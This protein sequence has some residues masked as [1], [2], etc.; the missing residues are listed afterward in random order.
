MIKKKFR[1]IAAIC[2]ASAMLIQSSVQGFAAETAGPADVQAQTAEG[3]IQAKSE[4]QTQATEAQTQATEAQT[5]ATEAQTQATEAQTQSTEA[6]TQATEALTQATE[7]QTQATESQTQATEGQTQAAGSQAQNAGSQTQATEAQTQATESQTQA[8]SEKSTESQT[9]GKETERSERVNDGEKFSSSQLET[10]LGSAFPYLFA[11]DTVEIP[12][13]LS[14][15]KKIAEGEE[16]SSIVS[17]LVPLSVKLANA[18]S[19]SD[20]EVVNLYA[21]EKGKLDTAQLDEITKK[22]VIDVTKKYYVVNIVA[23]H[24]DQD[25]DFS[26]YKMTLSGQPVTYE[27]ETQPGDILYNFVSLDGDKYQDYTGTLKLSNGAGLQGTFLAPRASVQIQS[28]LAGAVYAHDISVSDSVKE[29]L[30]IVFIQGQPESIAEEAKSGQIESGAEESESSLTESITEKSDGEQS[31]SSAVESTGESTGSEISEGADVITAD[32]E[33]EVLD[34]AEYLSDEDEIEPLDDD[35]EN[36]GSISLKVIEKGSDASET[37]IYIQDA[38]FVV[39]DSDGKILKDADGNPMYLITYHGGTEGEDTAA[40]TIQGFKK[41]ETYLLSQ[42]STDEGYE[43]AED[44]EFTIPA[45]GDSEGSASPEALPVK[46]TNRRISEVDTNSISVKADAFC[47]GVLLTAEEGRKSKYYAALFSD[48]TCTARVSA[49]K[50]VV[51]DGNAQK[52]Q[53][54]VFRGLEAGARYY[55]APTNELGEALQSGTFE[56]YEVNGENKISVVY[57]GITFSEMPVTREATDPVYEQKTV[58]LSYLFSPDSTINPYPEG[59]FSYIANIK[60]T[61]NLLDQSGNALIGQADDTFYVD[62]YRDSSRTQKVTQTPIT[63]AM[64]DKSTMEATYELKMTAGKADFYLS[65]TDQ[66]GKVVGGEKGD[67][68]YT[69]SY[70]P[71]ADGK[72]SIVCGSEFTAQIR[73]QINA[74]T[75]STRLVDAKTGKHISGVTMVIKDQDGKVVYNNGKALVFQSKDTD[76]VLENVLETGKNYY[77]SQVAAPSGYAP[78]ADVAFEVARGMVTEVVMQS[79]AAEKTSYSVTVNKQVYSGKYQVYAQDDTNGTNAANGSYTFHVALFADANHTQKVSDVQAITVKGLSGVTTFEN[80]QAKGST[81]ETATYYVAET[82]QYGE[83]L[84]STGNHTIKYAKSGKVTMDIKSKTTLIQNVY[85]SLPKGYRYTAKLTLTKKVVKSTGAAEKVTETFYAGIFRESDYS[86]TPTIIK[87]DLQDASSV[88]VSRRILFKP[89]GDETTYYIAEVDENGSILNQSE[90]FGYNVEIDKP[91]LKISKGDNASVTITNQPK[92]SK[93]TLYLTKKVYQGTLQKKVNETFYVGLFKDSNF[94]TP[95]TKPIP[96]KLENKSELTLKLSL[97]LGS[98]S[99]ATIY[100]A[101]VDKDGKVIK[102]EQEFG[103]EIKLVNSTAAFTPEK[104][105]I[106]TIILN[107]VY[108]SVTADDWKQI[109]HEDGN[110][111]GSDEMISGN[112]EASVAAQTGDTT[113]IK[114]YVILMAV[115]VMILG[116]CYRKKRR[117][118]L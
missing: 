108:G 40:Q 23:D 56:A 16:G 54:I 8:A 77:L 50:E 90:E 22:Q 88:Q 42:L 28:D 107:S 14:E 4:G 85:S 43:I 72:L 80:V 97:N 69:V 25:L 21:D 66:N 117:C 84:T 62:L 94:T 19:S 116:V 109:L 20:V 79:S 81:G 46:V 48:Q 1:R 110:Y 71:N 39:K 10:A 111:L 61:K 33:E 15:D 57:T 114:F 89:D 45:G 47:N 63:F 74:S 95:Y 58:E 13:S 102:N 91:T 83:P 18:V 24:P 101:E 75:V 68:V 78:S 65:E 86:G 36:T 52:S 29:L 5:Q 11:A 92:A 93:V 51:F 115:S 2:L 82:D 118:K 73:N 32:G 99:S 100:V 112:G 31:E 9:E 106:Q 27:E 41:G 35:G 26:G 105:E 44:K 53:Q 67:S 3:Q 49:V 34:L 70:L 60:L 17:G 113:P 103:Y 64:Q 12:E 98:S 55:L 38:V 37:P 104:R 7:S 96:M 6:Q 30:Q 87:L 59:D 76:Y